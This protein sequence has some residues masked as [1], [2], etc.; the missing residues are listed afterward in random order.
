[1]QEMFLG[2]LLLGCQQE[3]GFLYHEKHDIIS[4]NACFASRSHGKED[5]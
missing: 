3:E 2:H 4:V 5:F 1:M